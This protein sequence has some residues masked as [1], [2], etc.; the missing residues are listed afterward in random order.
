MGGGGVKSSKL[1]KFSSRN[2]QICNSEVDFSLV[3]K[4]TIR[5]LLNPYK[6]GYAAICLLLN[7]IISNFSHMEK[8]K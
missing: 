2:L 8:N 1:Y 4:R 7:L 3:T 5:V 6:I